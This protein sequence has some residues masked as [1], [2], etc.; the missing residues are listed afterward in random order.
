MAES[1]LMALMEMVSLL[2]SNTLGTLAGLARLFLE[3]MAHI[4]LVMGTSSG[5]FVLGFMLLGAVAFFLAKFV[6]SSGK[7][8]LMLIA[9]GVVLF[10][11]LFIGISM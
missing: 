7:A 10:V 11:V 4:G 6:F 9:A 3:F 8:I 5:G 1:A 2:I